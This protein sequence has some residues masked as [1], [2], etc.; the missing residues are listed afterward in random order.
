MTY[1][2]RKADL[3]RTSSTLSLVVIAV[4]TDVPP[5]RTQM[6][7]TQKLWG[8]ALGNPKSEL[9]NRPLFSYWFIA[10]IVRYVYSPRVAQACRLMDVD[11]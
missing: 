3:W 5:V 7:V 9:I 6:A 1:Y 8:E 4:D 11:F 2:R 10:H